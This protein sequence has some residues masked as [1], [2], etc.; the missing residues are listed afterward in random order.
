MTLEFVFKQATGKTCDELSSAGILDWYSEYA[1]GR[2]AGKG[3]LAANWN[4]FPRL[5][6]GSWPRTP[7]S[8]TAQEYNW[9]RKGRRFGD[10]LER[11]GYQLEWSDQVSRCDD[12]G[13]CIQ[14]EPDCHGW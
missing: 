7:E 1:D 2:D 5:N 12:C 3:I 8:E 6:A 10:I 14:T 4:H 9:S 11:M 13:G